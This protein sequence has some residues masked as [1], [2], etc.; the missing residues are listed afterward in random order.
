MGPNQILKGPAPV[1]TGEDSPPGNTDS[2]TANRKAD[3]GDLQFW[4]IVARSGAWSL[5]SGFAVRNVPFISFFALPI[6]IEELANQHCYATSKSREQKTQAERSTTSGLFNNK[7]LFHACTTIEQQISQVEGF[8]GLF[9][10]TRSRIPDQHPFHILWAI[11]SKGYPLTM[12]A[13]AFTECRDV[14]QMVARLDALQSVPAKQHATKNI[15]SDFLCNTSKF[16]TVAESN[17]FAVDDVL[18]VDPLKFTK[19]SAPMFFS[20]SFSGAKCQSNYEMTTC[21]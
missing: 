15:I 7:T 18:G 20:F 19:V 11:F 1:S 3:L 6:Y 5:F 21:P 10:E 12:L 9:Q 17:L 4:R 14:A 13:N 16:L 8:G 2:H